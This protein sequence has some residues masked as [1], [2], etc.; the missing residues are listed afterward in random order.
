MTLFGNK[1]ILQWCSKGGY[2]GAVLFSPEI[3]AIFLN[4]YFIS[5]EYINKE[6]SYNASMCKLYA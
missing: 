2:E 6:Y 1:T 4:L 5:F 3:S